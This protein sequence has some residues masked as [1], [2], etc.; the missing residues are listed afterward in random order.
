[1]LHWC[2]KDDMEAGGGIQ[3]GES[4]TDARRRS[5]LASERGVS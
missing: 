1:M 5:I 2:A 4:I 3:T